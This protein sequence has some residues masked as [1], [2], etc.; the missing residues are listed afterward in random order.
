MVLEDEAVADPTVLYCPCSARRN[1]EEVAIPVEGRQR[2]DQ[3]PA[4]RLVE[5]I[6]F[7]LRETSRHGCARYADYYDARRRCRY[8]VAAGVCEDCSL[9]YRVEFRLGGNVQETSNHG[10]FS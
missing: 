8:V 6:L 4:N 7:L 9:P 3:K 5:G 10:V 1:P 2:S